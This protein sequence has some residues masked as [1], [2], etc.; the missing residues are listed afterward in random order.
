MFS[1]YYL[2]SVAQASSTGTAAEEI[3]STILK[4]WLIDH[5]SMADQTFWWFSY[6][7]VFTNSTFYHFYLEIVWSNDFSRNT[8]TCLWQ[9]P[10]KK[11]LS[12]FEILF[13]CSFGFLRGNIIHSFYNIFLIF[14]YDFMLN[15][16]LTFLT[17]LMFTERMKFYI[18]QKHETRLCWVLLGT[19]GKK[20][21]WRYY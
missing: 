13:N 12:K 19:A 5:K 20:T 2:G 11:K 15:P 8:V 6:Y 9:I 1:Y 4:W 3:K 16:I 17:R 21:W 18:F 10:S 14:Q 7:H